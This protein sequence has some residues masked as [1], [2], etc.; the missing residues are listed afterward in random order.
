MAK[1]TFTKGVLIFELHFCTTACSF[2]SFEFQW[3]WSSSNWTDFTNWR[4]SYIDGGA[5]I[6]L[7]S[8]NWYSADARGRRRWCRRKCGRGIVYRYDR[9]TSFE[10][11][12]IESKNLIELVN[13][14]RS[15][16]TTTKVKILTTERS[17]FRYNVTEILTHRARCSIFCKNLCCSESQTFS[18][19]VARKYFK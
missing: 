6:A 13:K 4:R 7:P 12:L 8:R 10:N 18:Y 5:D 15:S 3:S 17:E 14:S 19:C 11:F 2:K 1:T 9:P 16:Y